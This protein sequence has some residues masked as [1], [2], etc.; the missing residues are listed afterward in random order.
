MRCNEIPETGLWLIG[1]PERLILPFPV[2]PPQRG[3]AD[4]VDP[5][6]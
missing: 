5:T 6:R 2:H 4:L 3:V 1:L